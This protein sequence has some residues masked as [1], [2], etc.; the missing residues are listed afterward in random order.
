MID[1]SICI[2][3]FLIPFKYVKYSNIQ[4]LLGLSVPK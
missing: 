1:V 4:D 3:P 2:L